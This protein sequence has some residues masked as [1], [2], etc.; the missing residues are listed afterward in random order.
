MT[1][2][3]VRD[4]QEADLPEVL[5]LE[6]DS[7]P[8]PWPLESFRHELHN[9]PYARNYVIRA[10]DA[11]LAGY[12]SIW[13]LE[14]ELYINNLNVAPAYRGRRLGHRI[15]RHLLETGRHGGCHSAVLEV[16]PSNEAALRLYRAQQFRTLGRRP[17][18]YSDGEDALILGRRL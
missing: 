18:Y 9:N 10:E 17:R 5:Q 14:G 12:A 2:Y 15:L 4:M 11:S 1:G 13:L 8:T 3:D 7:F 16:R 6:R